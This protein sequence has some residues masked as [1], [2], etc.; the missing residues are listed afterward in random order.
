MYVY[1]VFQILIFRKLHFT[2]RKDFFEVFEASG[3]IFI[4]NSKSHS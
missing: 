2:A 1:L 3:E 4:S